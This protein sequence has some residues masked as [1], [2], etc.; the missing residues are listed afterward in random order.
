MTKD[1]RVFFYAGNKR[2]SMAPSLTS[3]DVVITT[4]GTLTA[5]KNR[6]AKRSSDEDQPLLSHSWFRIVLDEGKDL[7]SLRHL[8]VGSTS[9]VNEHQLMLYGMLLQNNVPLHAL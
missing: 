4:Y 2:K 9:N 5:E 3:H 6:R 8:R 7:L 1:I